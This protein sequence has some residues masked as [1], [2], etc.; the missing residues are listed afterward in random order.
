MWPLTLFRRGLAGLVPREALREVLLVS[1]TYTSPLVGWAAVHSGRSMGV[2]PTK[3]AAPRVFSRIWSMLPNS[4]FSVRPA[5]FLVPSASA[6]HSPL[7]LASKRATY[8]V[9]WSRYLAPTA[10]RSA[11]SASLGSHTAVVTNL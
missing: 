10:R 6:S 3:S 8:S 2:A 4:S 5:A 9:P 11:R 1:V 7:P